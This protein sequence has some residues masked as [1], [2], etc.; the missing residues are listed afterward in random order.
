MVQ[1]VVDI[2]LDD[3]LPA[4]IDAS[5]SGQTQL[6]AAETGRRIRVV[7]YT[8]VVGG[9]VDIIFQSDSTNLTGTMEFGV[10]GEGAGRESSR[11][12][13]QT[14]V[15]EPLNLNLSANEGVGGHLLYLLV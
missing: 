5:A 11:W 9:A 7:E 14:A 12:L 13:F 4:V 15:G 1:A 6:V 8:L 3:Y 10:K 2:A